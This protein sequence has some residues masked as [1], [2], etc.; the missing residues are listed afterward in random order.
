MLA[1]E[2]ETFATHTGIYAWTHQECW[3]NS[4]EL[5]TVAA[6]AAAFLI[7]VLQMTSSKQ[8]CCTTT[9]HLD[10]GTAEKTCLLMCDTKVPIIVPE[11]GLLQLC[12]H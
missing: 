6:S 12:I 1:D 7:Q 5:A 4:V 11:P 10:K 9:A 3:Y 8:A 2:L